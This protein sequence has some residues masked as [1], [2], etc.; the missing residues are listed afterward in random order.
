VGDEESGGGFSVKIGERLEH[1]RS[2]EV[3]LGEE[4]S[5]NF[6]VSLSFS[7]YA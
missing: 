2:K 6:S 4:G 5:G 7:L 1:V 3:G